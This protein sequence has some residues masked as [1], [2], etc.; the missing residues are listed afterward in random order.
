[1][2]PSKSI[3]GMNH[4]FRQIQNYNGTWSQ[5]TLLTAYSTDTVV[6]RS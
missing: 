3:L 5:K 6:S 1:M 2:L 4:N